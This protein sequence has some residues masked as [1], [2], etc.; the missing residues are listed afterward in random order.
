MVFYSPPSE[1]CSRANWRKRIAK[2]S[3]VDLRRILRPRTPNPSSVFRGEGTGDRVTDLTDANPEYPEQPFEMG[4]E[5]GK[6]DKDTTAKRGQLP[7]NPTTSVL[8]R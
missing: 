8:S 4:M 1:D 2:N 6:S 5:V 7:P 3:L